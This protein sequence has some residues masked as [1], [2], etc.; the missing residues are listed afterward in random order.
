[1]PLLDHFGIIAPYY[2]RIFGTNYLDDWLELLELPT[3]GFILDAGGGT[4]RVA[5]L[6]QNKTCSVVVADLSLK[7]L[8]HA[9]SKPDL[10]GVCTPV[11]KL[12]FPDKMFDRIIMV[13]SLHHVE[14]QELTCHELWRILKPGG[15]LLIEEPDIRR[16]EIKILAI[17][18]KFA[19]MRSNFLSLSQIKAF[20]KDYPAKIRSQVKDTNV[21]IVIERTD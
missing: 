1:M 6:L 13:D 10:I 14:N 9:V 16:F 20:F 17:M 19:L 15:K 2:D 3:S 8:R 21:W 18:E 5:Q 11:E 7:M 4:G 12:P